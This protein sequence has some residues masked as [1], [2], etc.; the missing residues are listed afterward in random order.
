MELQLIDICNN[1]NS[2]KFLKRCSQMD[3]R[4]I[5]IGGAALCYHGIREPGS[6]K[7][8]DIYIEPEMENVKKLMHVFQYI[9]VELVT[10]PIKMCQIDMKISIIN[11][12]FQIDILSPKENEVFDEL[13]E[14]SLTFDMLYPGIR[15]AHTSDIIKM[16]ERAVSITKQRLDVHAKD[17]RALKSD[18]S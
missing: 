15:I 3:A 10:D 6:I 16:K 17:L 2:V 13:Y 1:R 7:D 4:F 18:F 8:L 9:G 11:E 12:E 14:R 5:V